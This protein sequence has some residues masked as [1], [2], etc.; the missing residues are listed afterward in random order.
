MEATIK[1]KPT[2]TRTIALE[3]TLEPKPLGA[4][5]K[6]K[7]Y[8]ARTEAS[9]LMQCIITENNQIK[10]T[11]YDETK[12]RAHDSQIV[13]AKETLMFGHCVA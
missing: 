1:N 10:L 5:A 9:L 11:E 6:Y 3:R 8:L 12:K 7:K 2:K 4:L 13:R